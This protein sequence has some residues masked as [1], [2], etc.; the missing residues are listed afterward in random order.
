[1]ISILKNVKSTKQRAPPPKK[2][3]SAKLQLI[4]G[5]CLMFILLC[6]VHLTFTWLEKL[7]FSLDKNFSHDNDFFKV[8]IVKRV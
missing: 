1:M 5:M 6:E 3:G 7:L 2:D 8:L 4:N